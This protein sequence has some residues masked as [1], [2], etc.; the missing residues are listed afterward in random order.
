MGECHL[1]YLVSL[2]AN[3]DAAHTGS[4]CKSKHT[5][6][7]GGTFQKDI[8]AIG[9]F[10]HLNGLFF[11]LWFALF[12]L[13]V[14]SSCGKLIVSLGENNIARW[15]AS[16]EPGTCHSTTPTRD[17]L[18]PGATWESPSAV[19]SIVSASLVVLQG[20]E[21]LHPSFPRVQTLASS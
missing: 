13:L 20:E 2:Q 16:G 19:H 6:S 15:T 11:P 5:F 3:Q 8:Q 9:N 17:C 18:T 14:F 21:F 1:K 12:V 4:L 10:E 7:L